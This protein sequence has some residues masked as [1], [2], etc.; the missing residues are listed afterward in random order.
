LILTD[1][2]AGGKGEESVEAEECVSESGEL[3]SRP[4]FIAIM[5]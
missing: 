4:W 2:K 5:L 3:G 1:I